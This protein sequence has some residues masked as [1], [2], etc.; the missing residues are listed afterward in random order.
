[1]T[2]FLRIPFFAYGP[3]ILVLQMSEA[4]ETDDQRQKLI[5]ALPPYTVQYCSLPSESIQSLMFGMY[6]DSPSRHT[7]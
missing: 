7:P 6:P 5:E 2:N 4:D 1:M 3:G